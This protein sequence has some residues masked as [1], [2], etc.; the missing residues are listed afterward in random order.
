MAIDEVE[1]L[2][3]P[4]DDIMV[5][6]VAIAAVNLPGASRSFVFDVYWERKPLGLFAQSDRNISLT[7]TMQ[8]M[9]D[10]VRSDVTATNKLECAEYVAGATAVG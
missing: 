10:R 3:A 5:T 6:D 4:D 1:V 7:N 2:L 8:D 9:P